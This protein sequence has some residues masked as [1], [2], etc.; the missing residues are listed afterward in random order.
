MSSQPGSQNSLGAPKLILMAAGA[1][2]GDAPVLAR[3]GLLAKAFGARLIVCHVIQMPTTSAGNDLDGYPANEQERKTLDL[4]KKMAHEVLGAR[5]AEVEMKILHGDPVERTIEYAEYE[6][7]D[8]V[9]VGSSNRSGIKKA[10]L[11]SVS[12]GIAGKSK[13]SVLIVRDQLN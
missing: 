8:L 10:I 12:S 1:T 2:E 9:I 4:L 13:K 5:A 3:S 7:A 6:G 11:G